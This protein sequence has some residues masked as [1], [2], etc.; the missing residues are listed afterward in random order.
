MEITCKERGFETTSR[1]IKDHTPR[2][3]E[4]GKTIVH[5]S[6]SF[7]RGSTTKEK[8]RS[9]DNVG[10]EREEKKRDMCCLSP[11]RI[12]DL[13]HSVCRGCNLLEGNSKDA[14]KKNLDRCSRCIPGQFLKE[15]SKRKKSYT[16]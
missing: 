3:K 7:D 12:D 8:H 16:N 11:T 6:E 9:H 4:R 5:T 15:A 10:T 1:G 2:N 14:K 13:T